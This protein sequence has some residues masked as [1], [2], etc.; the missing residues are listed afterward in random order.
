MCLKGGPRCY[1]HAIAAVEKTEDK[2]ASAAFEKDTLRESYNDANRTMHAYQGKDQNIKDG[3]TN[4][5]NDAYKNY[6]DSVEVSNALEEKLLRLKNEADATPQGMDVLLEKMNDPKNSRFFGAYNNRYLS[7]QR[8]YSIDLENHDRRENTVNGRKPSTYGTQ[9]GLDELSKRRK[10]NERKLANLYKK[11]LLEGNT[12]DLDKK[13][14]KGKKF[15][16]NIIKRQSHAHQT[17]THRQNG[18]IK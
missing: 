14:E 10:D 9:E 7:A 8:K 2:A 11:G 12:P 13:I 6:S 16:Q 1:G 18:I 15:H 3:L 4:A 5:R 17:F